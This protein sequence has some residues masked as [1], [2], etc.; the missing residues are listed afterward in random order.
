MFIV[1][2]LYCRNFLVGCVINFFVFIFFSNFIFCLGVFLNNFR[3]FGILFSCFFI[4]G[5]IKSC[6][7]LDI[8]VFK[9][10][11]KFLNVELLLLFVNI[12][13]LFSNNIKF[14]FFNFWIIECNNFLN[15]LGFFFKFLSEIKLI[16]CVVF[17]EFLKIF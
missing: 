13:N 3:S 2:L 10:L 14:L 16:L 6:F 4:I 15:L 17:F 12:L 7:F 8:I 9:Y 1:F 11:K 5:I